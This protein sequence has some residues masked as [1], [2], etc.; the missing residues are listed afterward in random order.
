MQNLVKKSKKMFKEVQERLKYKKSKRHKKG[1]KE[2]K[3]LKDP[4]IVFLKVLS[5]K[6]CHL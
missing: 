6:W 1:K 2:D 5:T 4:F 3:I